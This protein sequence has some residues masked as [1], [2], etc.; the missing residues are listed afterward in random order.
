MPDRLNASSES[1]NG[2]STPPS[3]MTD[4]T[5][6]GAGA[7]I[8]GSISLPGDAII[9][10]SIEGTLDVSGTLTIG[11]DA[12][13]DA[14]IRC[15]QLVLHGS[16]TGDVTAT[17]GLDL[18]DGATL[19]GDVVAD[20]VHVPSGAS[21]LGQLRIGNPPKSPPAKATRTRSETVL[22]I[23]TRSD[24][25]VADTTELET[26]VAGMPVTNGRR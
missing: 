23:D 13:V 21:Y 16:V 26:L 12:S 18:T 9:A 4:Q 2:A 14:T 7:A 25:D 17:S 19:V 3:L 6:L 22:T 5:V 24:D 8:T 10:G 1:T 11:P 20:H 15:R